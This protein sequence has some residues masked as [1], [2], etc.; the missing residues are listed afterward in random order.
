M[1]SQAPDV[2]FDDP[3]FERYQSA[4]NLDYDE[5]T[6]KMAVEI[7]KDAFAA[8]HPDNADAAPR[9]LTG[10]SAAAAV[11]TTMK[12]FV[13]DAIVHDE[14]GEEHSAE[15]I[16]RAHGSLD[17]A[18]RRS[19]LPEESVQLSDGSSRTRSQ[20][21]QGHDDRLDAVAQ[22]ETRG[23]FEHYARQPSW[24]IR[25]LIV[26]VL[27]L[28]EVFL[29]LWPVTNASWGDPASVAYVAGLMAMFVVM[30]EQ[31][32]KLAGTATRAAR[33]AH[34]AAHELTAVG[35]TAG[36]GGDLATGRA[37]LG[38]V[39]QRFV[40]AAEHKR[41]MRWALLST[42]ITIYAGVMF[43][44]VERLASGL[45]W[46]LLFVLLAA[47]LIT[48]FTAGAVILLAWWWAR[49]NAL[50]DQL[51]EYGE[52]TAESR[53]LAEQ[54]GDQS[55]EEA[56]SSSE[57]AEQAQLELDLGEQVIQD[58]YQLTGIGLQKAAK[59]LDQPAVLAPRPENLF[60]VGRAIRARVSNNLERA[61][62]ILAE[63]R[64][65]L[66]GPAPFAPT[67]PAANP[68]ETRTATRHALPNTT[69]V[70]PSQL[71]SLHTAPPSRSTPRWQ[72]RR[73]LSGV[74]LFL[75]LSTLLAAA[76]LIHLHT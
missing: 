12:K 51:R 4:H 10:P 30:N 41:T 21:Q 38:H 29:L 8:G 9:V 32:P 7:A 6:T 58:G 46:P 11:Q 65:T 39:D 56:R 36:R 19:R 1:S 68:W 74:A 63:A 28:I 15:A 25:A 73:W 62:T 55:R 54:L 20:A 75:V 60:A 69:F 3:H 37:V 34:D 76:L 48:A 66:N 17:T 33:E 53:M 22:R 44:R 71:G 26:P 5:L 67:R 43:T 16:R 14:V 52:I 24:M 64:Q 72:R 42:V 23:D 49:G 18:R 2:A 27:A 59:I 50:G 57:A 13:D 70:D 40:R 35:V 45:G 61:A 31:L 47:A